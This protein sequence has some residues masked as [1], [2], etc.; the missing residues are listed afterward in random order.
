MEFDVE[1]LSVETRSAANFAADESGRKEVHFQFDGSCAFAFRTAS[2]RAVEGEAPGQIA[3]QPGFRN[4]GEQLPDIVE[5]ANIG[6][7]NG[8][9]RPA[10]RR[11]VDF[12]HCLY[13]L[14]IGDS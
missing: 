1:G 14:V 8:P 2:L 6:C 10:D 7:G 3:A 13:V 5:K 4:L 11:L 12:V 9:R